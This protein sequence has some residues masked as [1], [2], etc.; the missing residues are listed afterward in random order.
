[1]ARQYEAMVKAERALRRGEI[2]RESGGNR[3]WRQ[4]DP[5]GNAA[6]SIAMHSK[7]DKIRAIEESVQAAGPGIYTWLLRGVTQGKTFEQLN[8]PCG[9]AQFYQARRRFFMELDR[10]LA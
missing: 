3:H 9:R 4:S 6:I 7:A 8:P 1:M 10:R 5:T 2:D